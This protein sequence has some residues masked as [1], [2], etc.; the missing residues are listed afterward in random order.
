MIESNCWELE[1]EYFRLKERAR[2][3]NLLEKKVPFTFEQTVQ[4][5]I[6]LF[7]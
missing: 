6:C 4:V 1:S 5:D 3:I 2:G 7:L